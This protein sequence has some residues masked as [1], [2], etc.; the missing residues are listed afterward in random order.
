MLTID[1]TNMF[2]PAVDGGVSEAEWEGAR[3]RF[4]EAHASVAAKRRSG[5]LG[6]L[7]LPSDE[8]LLG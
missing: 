5:E 3:G 6:F 8:R 2:A 1:Y 7:D 4:A